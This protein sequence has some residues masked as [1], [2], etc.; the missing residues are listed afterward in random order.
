M[1]TRNSNKVSLMNK[2]VNSVGKKLNDHDTYLRAFF[3]SLYRI[4]ASLR[5]VAGWKEFS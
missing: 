5:L 3:F 4:T 2:S 1:E